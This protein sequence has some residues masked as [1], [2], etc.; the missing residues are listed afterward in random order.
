M[1]RK[2]KEKV[3]D[4]RRR[5]P[6][7]M[8]LRHALIAQEEGGSEGWRGRGWPRIRKKALARD[9]N[10]STVSGFT[11]EQGRGLQVDHIHPFRLG[12]SNKLNN[13][14]T[15]DFYSNPHTDAMRGASEKSSKLR[16]FGDRK[17]K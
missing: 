3:G 9:G 11:A 15:T 17:R 8:R 7:P 13:L 16:G 12:G 5:H 4:H 6:L 1:S 10:R 14:R 2:P